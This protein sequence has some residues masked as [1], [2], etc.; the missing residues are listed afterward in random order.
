MRYLLFPF[1]WIYSAVVFLRN[2]LYDWGVLKSRTF[3]VPLIVIGNLAIGGTGKTPHTEYIIRL[4][5][6]KYR[7]AVLS[8]GYGRITKGYR[9]ANS[10]STP[11][12]IGDEPFQMYTKFPAL[13]L[14]VCEDRTLGINSLL[15]LDYPPEVILL[16]DAF[17]HRKIKAGLN[18]VLTEYDNPFYR[19]Y[20]IPMGKL[21]DNKREIKRAQIL[22]H[23]KVP[24]GEREQPIKINNARFSRPESFW[25]SFKYIGAKAYFPLNQNEKISKKIIVVTGIANPKPFVNYLR[26]NHEIVYKFSFRDHQDFNQSNLDEIL[27][28]KRNF[29][30]E[31]ISIVTTEK[32]FV[33]LSR[34]AQ[35]SNNF[36][37]VPIEVEFLSKQD[38]FDQLI[39]T[40]IN[41]L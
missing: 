18:I 8:R 3:E 21:R 13:T 28:K 1:S 19:D 32:D 6:D 30:D 14:A 2:R 40:Y 36:Y 7:I 26:E 35:P 41:S 5:K 20:M 29:G 34:F 10:N 38:E 15:N 23:T 12:E 31:Q 11:Q 17:Q 4:L 37:Y 24:E 16:D 25:S 27:K 33:K 22:I 9:L 39:K